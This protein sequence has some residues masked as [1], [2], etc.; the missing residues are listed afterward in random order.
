M[1]MQRGQ[2]VTA[3]PPTLT[4]GI[5]VTNNISVNGSFLGRSI[6]RLERKGKIDLEHLTEAFVRD[7]WEPFAKHAA[8]KPFI[9]KWSDNSAYSSEIGYCFAENIVAPR[10]A[11]N[12]FMSVEMPMRMLVS[13]SNQVT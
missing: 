13:D 10:N 1:E 5:K 7:T 11:G 6:K 8:T 4:Q 3:T 9:F 2:W 12:S